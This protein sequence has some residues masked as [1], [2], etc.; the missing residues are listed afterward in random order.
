MNKTLTDATL[1]LAIYDRRGAVVR[2]KTLSELDGLG[3]PNMGAV[4]ALCTQLIKDGYLQ[5]AGTTKDGLVKAVKPTDKA[6]EG[7]DELR[8]KNE[9]LCEWHALYEEV[10]AHRAEQ[11]IF[12]FPYT[13]VDDIDAARGREEW[14]TV[15]RWTAKLRECLQARFPNGLPPSFKKMLV[16]H[17]LR[18]DEQAVGLEFHDAEEAS[19]FKRDAAVGTSRSQ[20]L[21][22]A[23][24]PRLL[25]M[26]W[27]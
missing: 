20:S 1:M 16:E 15:E 7:A 18:E 21:A 26:R 12:W 8:K 3:R 13:L 25:K 11:A 24:P 6:H 23:Q 10:K 5:Q 19:M 27:R 9:A 2:L 14:D 22:T 17:G 4:R